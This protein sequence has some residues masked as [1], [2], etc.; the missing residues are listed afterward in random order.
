MSDTPPKV[1]EFFVAFIIAAIPII[2]IAFLRDG[3]KHI[4][5]HDLLCLGTILLPLGIMF[6]LYK[7]L[8][9]QRR[10][11]PPKETIQTIRFDD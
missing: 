4:E 8:E 7:V 10:N 1:K 11:K 3:F 2:I 6:V 9:R 5:S